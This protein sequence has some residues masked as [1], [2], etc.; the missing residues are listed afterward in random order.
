MYIQR[1]R[2]IQINGLLLLR[3]LETCEAREPDFPRVWF[4]SAGFASVAIISKRSFRL[5]EKEPFLIL[6]IPEE[7]KPGSR[8]V[9]SHYL[10]YCVRLFCPEKSHSGWYHVQNLNFNAS[11]DSRQPSIYWSTL[12]MISWELI[13]FAVILQ[14]PL[15]P[16]R[17]MIGCERPE[18]ISMAYKLRHKPF[19][20]S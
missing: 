10:D 14:K 13:L 12:E 18:R 17:S 19:K 9:Q 5:E 6:L 3:W 8:T 2:A 11:L 4:T 20:P 7:R 15:G 16:V 1:L